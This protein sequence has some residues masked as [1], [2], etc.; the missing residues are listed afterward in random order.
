MV[1]PGALRPVGAIAPEVSVVSVPLGFTRTRA[2]SGAII[3]TLATAPE[4]RVKSTMSCPGVVAAHISGK[5]YGSVRR[6]SECQA[7]SKTERECSSAKP[8]NL[9]KF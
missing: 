9:E 6:R 1:V 7:E 3:C 4:S 5:F 2:R 8:R